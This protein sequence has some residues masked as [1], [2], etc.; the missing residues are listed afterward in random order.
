MPSRW[1][2]W[3]AAAV[4]SIVCGQPAAPSDADSPSTTEAS[5]RRRKQAGW[6]GGSAWGCTSLCLVGRLA[7]LAI[8][9]AGSPRTAPERRKSPTYSS[10]DDA[11]SGACSQPS[12]RT[13]GVGGGSRT[14][15]NNFADCYLTV[16]FHQHEGDSIIHLHTQAT[17][18][19]APRWRAHADASAGEAPC[20][21]SSVAEPS[22][23]PWIATHLGPT[24]LRG[25]RGLPGDFGRAV[26][27][28]YGARKFLVSPS[29]AIRGIWTS[30]QQST[31]DSNPHLQLERL[32]CADQAHW[33][34]IDA[35]SADEPTARLGEALRRQATRCRQAT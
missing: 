35:A 4:A 29:K 15:L 28:P 6:R 32:M 3:T 20:T 30:P 2:R 31:W 14:R 9:L 12:E 21:P 27:V 10:L 13:S 17:Q 8:R 1:R 25:S 24:S 7:E 11:V 18:L 22:R 23:P 19:G 33:W 34:T 16:W 26:L 5:C